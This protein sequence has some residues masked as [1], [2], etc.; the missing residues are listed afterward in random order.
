M[1]L[2]AKFL[3]EIPLNK[4]KLDDYETVVLIE[5][6]NAILQN[7]LPPK[8][9]DPRSFSI[10]C[11]ISNMNIDKALY[12]KGAS[13]SLMPL[14]TCQK[15]N[16][17]ELKWTTISLQLADRYVKY[18]IGILEN[19]PIKIGKF[20]IPTDFIV[21]EKDKDVQIP[22]ILGRPFLATGRAIIDVKNGQLTLKVGEEEVEFN[23]FHAMKQKQDMDKCLRVDISDELVEEEFNQRYPEEPLE[24]YIMHSNT[25]KNENKK[26]AAVAQ[27]LEASQSPPLA[28]VEELKQTPT[29]STSNNEATQ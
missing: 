13:V 27:S 29:M 12:N 2:Y 18:P 16:V 9:K 23:L 8:L 20:F 24:T 10:P 6:C 5:E 3:K 4:W 26:I 25:A 28:Q 22:I 15:L 7:K 17:G 1:S 14:S 19:I 11:L 21:L